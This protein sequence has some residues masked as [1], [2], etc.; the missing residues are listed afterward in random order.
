VPVHGLARTRMAEG[1]A[2]DISWRVRPLTIE[3]GTTRNAR[4][5][6]QVALNTQGMQ[7]FPV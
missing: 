5:S 7:F 4:V 6:D 3:A 2:I 1:G